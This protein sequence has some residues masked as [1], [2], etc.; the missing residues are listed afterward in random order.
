MPQPPNDHERFM[1]LFLE[2]EPTI[3]RAVLVFVPERADAR[4]I[5]Q[6]TAVALWKQFDQY[7]GTRPFANWAIGFARIQVRRFLRNGA[8]RVAL[9]ERAAELIEQAQDE[10]AAVKEKR[11]LA[12]RECLDALPA[13]S[14]GIIN[15]YY[16][17]EQTVE[18]LAQTHGRSVDA[19]Y[20]TLQRL[21]ASL[22][23]C[24]NSKLSPA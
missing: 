8:R 16:F 17:E 1:R 4:D 20:K 21:R 22:L 15:G 18:N 13:Q 23:D 2:H 9:S 7:D 6:E 12:L 14:R 19:I 10:R 24:I 5:V 3:L 11:D